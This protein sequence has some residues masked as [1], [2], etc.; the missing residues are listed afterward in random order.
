MSNPT[1]GA[2]GFGIQS[3]AA[4][5]GGETATAALSATEEYSGYTWSAGG[6]LPATRY[7]NIGVGTQTAGLSM[8]GLASPPN[9]P[10][11]ATDE[12]DG[13]TWTAGGSLPSGR[14]GGSQAGIQTAALFAGQMMQILV[15]LLQQKNIMVVHGQQVE[16]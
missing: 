2:A 15:I 8:G 11:T 4:R 1:G 5:A 10:T 6:N 14:F 9:V 7:Q 3:A 13:S 16:V 12:Y